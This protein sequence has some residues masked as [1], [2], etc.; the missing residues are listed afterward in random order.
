M[1][2]SV[3][4]IQEILKMLPHRYP[5]L[6]V[7]KVIQ[8][9]LGKSLIAIKN[10]T[11]NEP[12]FTGHFPEKPVFP[13]VLILEALAQAAGILSCKTRLESGEMSRDKRYLLLFAGVNNVRFKRLVI[14][15][16]QL[17]LNIEI[18]RHR[19]DFAT[20][21]ASAT[22]DGELACEAELLTAI[23]EVA[24]EQ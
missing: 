1:G 19:K 12:C 24:H 13:G 7:D 8:M 17:Q 23:K 3:V 22:V 4:D 6:M 14:P 16:D 10:I 11:A 20:F 15:G 2:T 21:K 9:E 5:F 18:K